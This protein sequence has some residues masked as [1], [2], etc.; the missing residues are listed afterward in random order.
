MGNIK[1]CRKLNF[2]GFLEHDRLSLKKYLPPK[3][4]CGIFFRRKSKMADIFKKR[5]TN[6]FFLLF[7]QFWIQGILKK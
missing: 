3:K 4:P 2:S 7:Q 5:Q 6:N 1:K